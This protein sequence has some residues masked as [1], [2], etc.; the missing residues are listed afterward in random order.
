MP[1]EKTSHGAPRRDMQYAMWCADA[2][3][4]KRYDMA[5]TNLDRQAAHRRHGLAGMA[6]GSGTAAVGSRSAMGH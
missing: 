3:T 2:R 5:R 1:T 6:G 4:T